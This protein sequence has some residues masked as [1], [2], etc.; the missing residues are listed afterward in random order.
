MDFLYE[1]KEYLEYL[2]RYKLFILFLYLSVEVGIFLKIGH[3]NILMFTSSLFVTIFIIC[4]MFL[5]FKDIKT[6]I[7]VYIF[8]MPLI[9]MILYLLA[10]LNM[11][12]IGS[13]IYW[14]YFIV[15]LINIFR[16]KQKVDFSLI[17]DRKKYKYVLF[18]YSLIIVLALISAFVNVNKL[19]SIN[20]VAL[21][22]IS[23]IILSVILLSYKELNDYFSKQI[24]TYLCMGAALSS[25]PDIIVT[26]YNLIFRGNNQHL[27]GVLGSNFML[28]YTL[29]ILPFILLF[30][31]NKEIFP[32]Y[33]ELYKLLL[34]V[35]VVNLCT[36]KSRGIMVAVGL[37]IFLV[38]LIDRKNYKKYIIIF[39]VVFVCLGFNITH[40]WEFNELREELKIEGIEVIT[41]SKGIIHEM[42]QQCKSRRPIWIVAYGMIYDHPYF[43]V[44]PGQF[45]NFYLTYGGN[46]N[47]MYIDAHNIFL[48]VATEFGL[49]FTFVLFISIIIVLVKSIIYAIKHKDDKKFILSAVIGMLCLLAYGNITGQAFMTSTYPISIIPAFV[50]M[51]IIT[52]MLKIIHKGERD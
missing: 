8:S 39:V 4:S 50:F 43:G 44:G 13:G 37:C 47:K 32:E 22:V 16:F 52:L 7:L 23:T 41:K 45:K 40:R 15:F 9:P 25:I 6:N 11:K 49:I 42:L 29:M 31:V 21:A 48:D 20:L 10:R 46:K 14:V 27:Y 5:M 35:E 2:K 1:C 36:Q 17:A 51:V 18:T 38:I 26:L 33:R 19:E 12:W 28:G 24:V 30:A 34:F 3:T